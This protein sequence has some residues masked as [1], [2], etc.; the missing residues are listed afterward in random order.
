MNGISFKSGF[1]NRYGNPL[2]DSCLENS[3]DGGAWLATVH[4]VAKRLSDFTSPQLVKYNFFELLASE[5]FTSCNNRDL[6][7][8]LFIEVIMQ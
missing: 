4:G 5:I 8:A 3:M 6:N 2:Q 1:E 7:C